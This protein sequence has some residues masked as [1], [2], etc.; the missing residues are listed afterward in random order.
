[1]RKL[2]ILRRPRSDRLEGRTMLIQSIRQRFERAIPEAVVDI[3]GT[4]LDPVLARIADD[5]RRGVEPHR[6]AVEQGAGEDLGIEAF[7]PGRDVN[8]ERKARRMALGKA[9]GAKPFDLAE[10]AGREIAVIAIFNHSGDKLVTEQVD[11]AVA[12]E[13]RHGATQP[14]GFLRGKPGSANGDLLRLL[15]K[16]RTAHGL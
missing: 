12:F 8:E 14:V 9:I 10:A 15:L 2:L 6:L 13:G 5:L 4:Y 16:E 1:M 11:V 7:D 3:D